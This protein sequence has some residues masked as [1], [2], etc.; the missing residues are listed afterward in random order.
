MLTELVAPAHM[1]GLD[2]VAPALVAGIELVAPAWAVQ[3]HP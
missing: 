1:A 2:L 3:N